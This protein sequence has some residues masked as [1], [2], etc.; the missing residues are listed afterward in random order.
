MHHRTTIA[1]IIICLAMPVA[2]EFRTVS[3]AY[4]IPLDFFSAPVS[5]NALAAFRQC[6]KCNSLSVRVTAST[7]YRVNGKSIT[8]K[9]FRKII[10]NVLDRS[11]KT[12]VV[13]HHLETDSIE[14]ILL[15]L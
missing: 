3:R 10:S 4:E 11:Q 12:I 15:T 7:D 2:A 9:E 14:R 13:L 6:N 1:A 5:D 8:L